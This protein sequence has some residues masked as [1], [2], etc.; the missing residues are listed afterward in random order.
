MMRKL[1][2]ALKAI[3]SKGL[4]RLGYKIIPAG[5]LTDRCTMDAAFRALKARKHAF[6]TVIDIGASNGSWSDQLMRYF[7]SCQYLLIEAQ[8]VHEPA[9]RDYCAQH[10]NA[11]FV[12][13]AAGEQAGNIFFNAAD[14]LG[15]QASYVP[16]PV[17]NI[18]VPVVAVD[19]EVR[20]RKLDG[21]YLLKFDTHGFEVPILKGA[22]NTLAKTDVI[23]MECYNFRIALECLTFDEMCRYLGERGFRCIDL[24]DPLYRPYDDSFWQMDL[25]FVR[26]SRPEFNYQG[27]R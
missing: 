19:A 3:I 13:A 23:V 26:D 9:L 18:Q 17:A 27:Y 11:Q 20:A 24:V 7:P 6:N 21:P 2:M 10:A 14:P 8:P 22:A 5:S 12:L 15:G 4:L 25:V 1:T 16:Y